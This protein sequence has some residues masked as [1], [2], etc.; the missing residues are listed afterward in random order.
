MKSIII[1]III[2]LTLF[3]FCY[4][5]N[6]PK[7]T[8]S[9]EDSLFKELISRYK[10]IPHYPL[11]GPNTFENL[12]PLQSSLMVY[13]S[14]TLR[15]DYHD[16]RLQ[17][18][19]GRIFPFFVLKLQNKIFPVPCDIIERAD[20]SLQ[21]C[22]ENQM[23]KFLFYR[24]ANWKLK[25]GFEKSTLNTLDAIFEGF[26]HVSRFNEQDTLIL[27]E[28]AH[29][30]IKYKS[31]HLSKKT[32]ID[33]L[34]HLINDSLSAFMADYRNN[35]QLA[36][37]TEKMVDASTENPEKLVIYYK[38]R[39]SH[40][41]LFLKLTIEKDKIKVFLYNPFRAYNLYM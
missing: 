9:V 5:K 29:S 36:W 7:K 27:K 17:G 12:F 21:L 2:C 38:N 24:H 32:E 11:T 1:P 28:M 16:D 20:T 13:A 40:F 14:D 6:I 25:R 31:I 23:N 19:A 8:N 35:A 41:Y 39:I 33:S 15:I 37:E 4:Q 22:F 10:Q 30:A 26:L 34:S 18:M 3:S